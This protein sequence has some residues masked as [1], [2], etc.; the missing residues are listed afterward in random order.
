MAEKE[1]I[2]FEVRGT[3]R[4]GEEWRPYRKEIKASSESQ[5]REHTF[6]LIGSKHRLK[7]RYITIDTVVHAEGKK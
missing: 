7:R 1:V 4:N 3:F 2:T 5:A 6:A